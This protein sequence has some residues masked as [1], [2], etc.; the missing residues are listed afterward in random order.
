MPNADH[1]PLTVAEK[2][3]LIEHGLVRHTYR[4][5]P[6]LCNDFDLYRLYSLIERERPQVVVEVGSYMGGRTLFYADGVQAGLVEMV[7]SVNLYPSWHYSLFG[8]PSVA[9]GKVSL[10]TGNS[11]GEALVA[12]VKRQVAD[13]RCLVVLDSDHRAEHVLRELQ[14]YSPLCQ[15][16]DYLIVE[17]GH[18]NLVLPGFGPGPLEATEQFLTACGGQELFEVDTAIEAMGGPYSHAPRGWLRRRAA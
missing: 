5:V 16:G 1:P 14:L 10:L 2:F 17:D 13:R 7:V 8:H 11:V 15:P 12:E 4:D 9:G 3:H 6:L 18:V